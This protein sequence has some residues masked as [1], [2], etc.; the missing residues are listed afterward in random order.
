MNKS[1]KLELIIGPM[2]SGKSTELIKKIRNM[3]VINVNYIV[4]KP[5]IDNRYEINKIISH[6]KDYE[7]LFDQNIE[8]TQ[9]KVK[10]IL[11]NDQCII[12]NDLMDITNDQISKFKCIII[13]EGQ[14]LLNLKIQVL[15]WVENLNKHVIIGGLDGDYKRNSI[16]EILKLIPFAD[17][18]KKYTA[19]CK[20]CNDE[21]PA[22][23]SHRILDVD[24]NQVLIGSIDTYIP[25]CRMHYLQNNN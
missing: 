15:N 20:L 12:T 2:F 21:T 10:N 16:G 6:D 14:F 19:L 11:F 13:D 3:K 23:F 7:K 5:L 4:I 9:N 22:L 18:Y 1:G 24:K 25:L 8:T 17:N